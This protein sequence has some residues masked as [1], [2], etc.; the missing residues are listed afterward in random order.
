MLNGLIFFLSKYDPNS[1]ATE[2][3]LIAF[4]VLESEPT[5]TIFICFSLIILELTIFT[6]F[7]VLINLSFQKIQY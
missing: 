7:M 2:L 6:P 3:K 4:K 1:V 5:R